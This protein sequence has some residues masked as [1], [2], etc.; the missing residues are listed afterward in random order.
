ML[1]ERDEAREQVAAEQRRICKATQK[2]GVTWAE[3]VLSTAPESK[4]LVPDGRRTPVVSLLNLKGG[5]GKTTTTAN[6]GAWLTRRGW[7]V[8]LID[9]DLQGSLTTLFLQDDE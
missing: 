6:L 8:V 3:K 1:T 2:D 4:P 7:R 9:L 5:V